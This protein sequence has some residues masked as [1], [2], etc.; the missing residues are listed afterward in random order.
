MSENL[1]DDMKGYRK[2]T[3]RERRKIEKDLCAAGVCEIVR[4]KLKPGEVVP[5]IG[6]VNYYVPTKK[7][8]Q[9]KPS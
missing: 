3:E 6:H 8:C 9:K 7:V 5:L 2:A 1:N 4:Y